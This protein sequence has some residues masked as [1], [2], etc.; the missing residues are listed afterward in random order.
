MVSLYEQRVVY[1]HKLKNL[2]EYTGSKHAKQFL[3]FNNDEQVYHKE[4]SNSVDSEN[5]VKTSKNTTTHS[6]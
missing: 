2:F 5:R 1:L 6:I 4:E 3:T